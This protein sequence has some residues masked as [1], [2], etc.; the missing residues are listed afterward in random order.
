MSFPLLQQQQRRRAPFFVSL[1][2]ILPDSYMRHARESTMMVAVSGEEPL[3]ANPCQISDFCKKYGNGYRFRYDF[4]PE[5]VMFR[6]VFAEKNISCFEAFFENER[7]AVIGRD[8]CVGLTMLAALGMISLKYGRLLAT[9]SQLG[10]S[11]VTAES[12]ETLEVFEDSF[13]GDDAEPC[14]QQLSYENV[15]SIFALTAK[16]LVSWNDR[17]GDGRN[18]ELTSFER[19]LLDLYVFSREAP[20]RESGIQTPDTVLSNFD[21]ATVP[22]TSDDVG[23]S[24]HRVAH[25]A[26]SRYLVPTRSVDPG[27]VSTDAEQQVQESESAD[28]EIRGVLDLAAEIRVALNLARDLARFV[29]KPRI[30]PSE[31]RALGP[32]CDGVRKSRRQM[33]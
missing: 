31:I 18:F 13:A 3:Q 15:D 30:R 14:G 22:A 10:Q 29:R 17:F 4:T 20:S 16:E 32:Q 25:T 6:H 12:T 33:R 2:D 5:L 21:V 7:V 8:D 1:G 9:V 26:D 11:A 19:R 23:V 28:A 27:P 24:A